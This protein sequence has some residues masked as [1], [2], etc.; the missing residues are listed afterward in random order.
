MLDPRAIA[1][2]LGGRAVHA[3]EEP[4][5]VV[6]GVVSLASDARKVDVLEVVGV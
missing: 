1:V 2:L 3:L 5:K 4:K 6:P